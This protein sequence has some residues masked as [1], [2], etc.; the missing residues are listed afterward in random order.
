MSF[1]EQIAK[2]CI[3]EL[4]GLIFTR[5]TKIQKLYFDSNFMSEAETED[6]LEKI[7]ASDSLRTLES[8]NLFT[9]FNLDGDRACELVAD[10]LD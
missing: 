6:M 2:T 1:L 8:V 5:A 4:V 10:L 3:L 9:S 7:L